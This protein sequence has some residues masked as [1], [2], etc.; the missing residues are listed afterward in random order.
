MLRAIVS[1]SLRFRGVIFA[2]AVITCAYGIYSLT[3]AK[4]DVFPEFAPPMTVVQTEA[5]GLSSEQVETLVTQPI[6]N[7]LGG[8]LGVKSMRSKSLQGLS[9]VTIVF[10]DGTDV[11][12]ARQ[13]VSERL[14]GLSVT[15]P[16]GAQPPKLL[17]LT[18]TTS[19]V[20]VVG[21]TSQRRS[22]LELHD[23]A[24]WTIRPQL[25]DIPG[26]A[27]AIVF[28]GA[29]RQLQVQVDPSKLVRYGLSISDVMSAVHTATGVRGAGFI[30]GSNQRMAVTTDG[31]VLTPAQLAGAVLSWKGGVG[32]HI[33]D[34][35]SVTYAAAFPV[36]AASIMANPA[37][38]VVVESQ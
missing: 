3:Q 21:I 23:L 6:E 24:E 7:A 36:G 4:L 8:T 38:M 32:I 15:F 29:A 2:L 12:Q 26:V 19:V 10:D 37:V 14:A 9:V 28:G 22:L 27:D 30:E 33:G 17:P 25:L 20:L 34:V 16:V 11:V 5:P 31:Q 18:T 13:L 35:A 1:F